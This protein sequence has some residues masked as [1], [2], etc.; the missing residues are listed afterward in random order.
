MIC[1]HFVNPATSHNFTHQTYHIGVPLCTRS[2]QFGDAGHLIWIVLTW[3]L[4]FLVL[5]APRRV[6]QSG[7]P[8]APD[9]QPPAGLKRLQGAGAPTAGNLQLGGDRVHNHRC[10]HAMQPT[11][12]TRHTQRFAPHS[13]SDLTALRPWF[14]LR[15]VQP[16]LAL[17]SGSEDA[18]APKSR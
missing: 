9:T 16:P 15:S 4:A 17:D 8:P 6:Q 3:P 2:R 18:L 10:V 7:I 14:P 12:C 5:P 13:V 11:L 1:R